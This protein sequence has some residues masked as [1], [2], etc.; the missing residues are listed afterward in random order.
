LIEGHT[1]SQGNDQANL[2]LSQAR[3]EAVRQYLVGRGV[4]QDKVRAVGRGEQQPVATNDSPEGR[5]NN[6]RVEIVVQNAVQA[7]TP[8]S[9]PR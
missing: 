2:A 6:R 5:A 7:A 3:A 4:A 8:S 9:A 1:D